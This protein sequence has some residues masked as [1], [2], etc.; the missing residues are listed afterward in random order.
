[1]VNGTTPFDQILCDLFFDGS[2]EGNG[3]KEQQNQT[4]NFKPYF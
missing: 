4:M 3:T 2:L 1:M